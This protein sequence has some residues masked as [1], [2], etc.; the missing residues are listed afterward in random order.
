[1]STGAAAVDHEDVPTICC[2]ACDTALASHHEDTATPMPPWM[3][4][5]SGSPVIESAALGLAVGDTDIG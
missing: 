3:I 4:T 2:P 1:M 5:G